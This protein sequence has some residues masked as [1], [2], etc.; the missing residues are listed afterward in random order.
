MASS[1]NGCQHDTELLLSECR[2]PHGWDLLHTAYSA[3][4]T[5]RPDCSTPMTIFSLELAR[6]LAAC[7]GVARPGSSPPAGSPPAG[8]AGAAHTAGTPGPCVRPVGQRAPSGRVS[9]GP[10]GL[11]FCA[12]TG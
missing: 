1:R 3:L 7:A 4:R 8:P 9:P 2:G 12:C 11:R 6:F 5:V 10:T